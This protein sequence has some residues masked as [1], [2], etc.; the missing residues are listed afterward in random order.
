METRGSKLLALI[1]IGIIELCI[2]NYDFAKV[3]RNNIF[4]LRNDKSKKLKSI[5]ELGLTQFQGTYI[6]DLSTNNQKKRINIIVLF[7]NFLKSDDEQIEKFRRFLD[8]VD[9]KEKNTIILFNLDQRF[10]DIQKYRNIQNQQ[11]QYQKNFQNNKINKN[12][13]ST[14]NLSKLL[15]E[16]FFLKLL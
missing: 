10:Y 9:S 7:K 6:I 13:M 1:M 8:Q 4:N 3:Q 2:Y 5:S 16:F 11:C 15:K 12:V 14:D